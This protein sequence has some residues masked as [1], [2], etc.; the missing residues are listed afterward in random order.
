M[1]HERSSCHFGD[2][3][4][5]REARSDDV[6]R[7][8]AH[9]PS[10]LHL[11]TIHRPHCQITIPTCQQQEARSETQKW[12][13]RSEH[14][15]LH[16]ALPWQVHLLTPPNSAI[17]VGCHNSQA[18]FHS[19]IFRTWFKL[20]VLYSYTSSIRMVPPALAPRDT[21][22]PTF[23]HHLR[24]QA[25]PH[26]HSIT[27]RTFRSTGLRLLTICHHTASCHQAAAQGS[28]GGWRACRLA[29]AW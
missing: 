9:L 24:P 18:P 11:E 2:L 17:E 29:S 10:P 19:S 25:R 1:Y 15:S 8:S 12:K 13:L 26:H 3:V 23:P 21:H 16:R 28:Q 20:F 5:A 6:T 4:E 14:F 7:T 22:Q 27:D